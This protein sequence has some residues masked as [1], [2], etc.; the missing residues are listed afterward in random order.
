MEKI[1]MSR[2]HN[3]DFDYHE[4]PPDH[5][6]SR[7]VLYRISRDTQNAESAPWPPD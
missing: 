3:G 1:G 7:H 4:L 5:H 6:L 2:D